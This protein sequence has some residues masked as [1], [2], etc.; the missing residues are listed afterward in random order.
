MF[1]Y[2]AQAYVFGNAT[3]NAIGAPLN[4]TL[5]YSV[6]LYQTGFIFLKMGYASAMAWILFFVILGCTLLMLRVS[7]R[8][9]YYSG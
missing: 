1:Q 4:S 5:F 6:Y 8:Y 9:T 3:N 2:F 7:S